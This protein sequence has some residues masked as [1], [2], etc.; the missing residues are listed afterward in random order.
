MS[1]SLIR[2]INL[3][4]NEQIIKMV[5][6]Q[7]L[8]FFWPMSIAIILIAA[9]FFFLF[10]LLQIERWGI[11][12]FFCFLALGISLIIRALILWYFNCWVITNFKVVDVDQ[13]RMFDRRVSEIP[14]EK[15]KDV[16]Y[17]AKGI[18]STIFRLGEVEILTNDEKLFFTIKKVGHPQEIQ[19]L[20][21]NLQLRKIEREI[22]GKN[23]SAQELIK[24]VEKIKKGIG[25]EKFRELVSA[26]KDTDRHEY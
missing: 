3:Q 1:L 14:L 22:D 6:G 13:R 23:L 12:I 17:R 21:V 2:K 24:L 18:I 4:E 25:E 11:I 26:S 9:P 10:L 19:Q 7:L 15:I 8:A 20:I 16:S 5:R